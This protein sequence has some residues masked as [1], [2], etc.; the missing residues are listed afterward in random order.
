VPL[1]SGAVPDPW[2][3]LI[4]GPGLL[5]P[6]ATAVLPWEAI[7]AAAMPAAR[8]PGK[9]PRVANR[10]INRAMVRVPRLV[11]LGVLAA[12]DPSAVVVGG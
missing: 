4:S 8:T 6:A 2:A 1:L 10:M 5:D 7:I 12:T 11:V 9:T 3:T